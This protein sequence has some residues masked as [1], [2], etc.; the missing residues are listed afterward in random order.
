M[1]EWLD[2]V[3][4]PKWTSDLW[5]WWQF[6]CENRQVWCVYGLLSCVIWV[7]WFHDSQPGVSGIPVKNTGTYGFLY[8]YQALLLWLV[9]VWHY[10]TRL[11]LCSLGAAAWWKMV[12]CARVRVRTGCCNKD[13]CFVQEWEWEQAVV[14]RTCVLCT[15]NCSST[16]LL[17]RHVSSKAPM[18]ILTQ[19]YTPGQ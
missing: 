12:K 1:A 8:Q 2:V 11:K 18:E 3:K 9:F 15:A 14:T 13:M 16:F 7:A 5:I 6:G 4:T 19:H 17:S 10:K